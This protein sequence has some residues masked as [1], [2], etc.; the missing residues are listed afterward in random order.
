MRGLSDW[1]KGVTFA[2]GWLRGKGPMGA[3]LA[4]QL[5]DE[6]SKYPD[7]EGTESRVVK[8]IADWFEENLGG[9]GPGETKDVAER[10][11]RGDWKRL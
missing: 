3:S 7:K 5:V 6:A 9:E 10:I 8:Q 4:G 11:R 1:E 2:V